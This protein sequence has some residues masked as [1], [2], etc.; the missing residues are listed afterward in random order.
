MKETYNNLPNWAKGAIAVGGVLI[1]GIFGYKIYQDV[2]RKRDLKDASQ[3][4]DQADT[5][6]RN[7]SNQ[8]IKPTISTSQATTLAQSLVQSMNGCGTDENKIYGV[9]EQ[10][11]NDADVYMLIK[12][13]GVRFY[14]PCAASNPVSYAKFL[15]NDKAFG[16]DLGT[17]MGYDLTNAEVQKIN[18][19]FAKKKIVFRF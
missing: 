2:K 14:T 4:S 10:L 12:Q 16:G 11:K 8:G 13:F 1:V 15:Y 17:W 9:F 19:I 7:L 18:G 6:L 3:A 5:E